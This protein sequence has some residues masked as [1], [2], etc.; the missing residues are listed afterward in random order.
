MLTSDW[1]LWEWIGKI[2][3]WSSL[4]LPQGQKARET[5]GAKARNCQ[6]TAARGRFL[7]QALEEKKWV[8]RRKH[9][10]EELSSHCL[11]VPDLAT[12]G[13][14][15]FICENVF[16]MADFLSF[17]FAKNTRSFVSPTACTSLRRESN[18]VIYAQRLQLRQAPQ[19]RQ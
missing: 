3:W 7:Q 13:E 12:S 6:V 1:T 16:R 2:I 15:V 19:S 17:Y 18:D 14:L 8:K 10:T 9:H 4:Q 11:E 5:P